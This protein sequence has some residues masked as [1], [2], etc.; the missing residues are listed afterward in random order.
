MKKQTTSADL[1]RFEM[2]SVSTLKPYAN[3]ARTHSPEQINKLRTSIREFGFVNPCLIDRDN[4]IIAGHGR[5]EAAKAEGIKEVPCV[6]VEHLTD[7][8]KRAYIIADNK[9]AELAGWDADM[10]KIELAS[11]EEIGFNAEITGFSVDEWKE[12]TKP[13][14]EP[15]HEEVKPYDRHH[16]LVSCDASMSPCVMQII[17]QLQ[18]V[19]GVEIDNGYN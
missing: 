16:I 18:S 7:A 19:E 9:L 12:Y 11:L 6:F 1:P 3:N 2:I 8:Q 5:V 17:N 4:M 13:D 15:K 14:Q 10:L